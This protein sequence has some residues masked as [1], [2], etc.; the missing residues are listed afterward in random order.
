M[1]TPKHSPLRP[2]LGKAVL[3]LLHAEM[4]FTRA[5]SLWIEG[6]EGRPREKPSDLDFWERRID[7]AQH[8]VQKWQAVARSA[9]L[10]ED[11]DEKDG[12]SP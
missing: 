4:E 9:G 7:E 5:Y 6:G 10:L 11:E 12:P 3:E 1:S 8:E 2:E